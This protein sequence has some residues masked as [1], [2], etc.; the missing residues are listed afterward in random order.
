M[1]IYRSENRAERF[2]NEIFASFTEEI[3]MSMLERTIFSPH[4]KGESFAIGVCSWLASCDDSVLTCQVRHHQSGKTIAFRFKIFH[5]H[6]V[7]QDVDDPGT[8]PEKAVRAILGTLK[9][10]ETGLRE[11]RFTLIG[12]HV[13]TWSPNMKEFWIGKGAKGYALEEVA[14]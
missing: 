6:D 5:E 12:I 4:T 2:I 14:V 13:A 3:A 9:S 7:F 1:L 8:Q 11:V 10:Q